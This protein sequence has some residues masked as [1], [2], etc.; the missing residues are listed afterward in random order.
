MFRTMKRLMALSFATSTP[1][2]SQRT[3][4]TCSAATAVGAGPACPLH[5]SPATPLAQHSCCDVNACRRTALPIL[6]T[7]T[8]AYKDRA[9]E[10]TRDCSKGRTWPRP[11]LLRPLLRLF[12]LMLGNAPR[13]TTRSS[14]LTSKLLKR[15]AAEQP[16]LDP[17]PA[18]L[19]SGGA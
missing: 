3:R 15:L 11:C 5:T 6:F 9:L 13:H 10:Q 19:S 4:F 14:E 18:L 1:D 7:T 12:L 16:P 2:A 8:G 17:V